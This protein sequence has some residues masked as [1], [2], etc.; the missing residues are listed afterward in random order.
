MVERAFFTLRYALLGYTFILSTLLVAYP[1]LDKIFSVA[2]ITS[3]D[4]FFITA[5]LTFFTLLSGGAIGFLVSQV[6]YFFHNIL[7]KAYFVRD[8]REFLK[9]TY[10]LSNNIRRQLTFLD[11][12]FHS[13]D[14]STIGYVQR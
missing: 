5:F 13:S 4:G 9:E 10:H 11:Y 6:W 14:K 8:S 2:E 7:L 12:V 3:N 1:N